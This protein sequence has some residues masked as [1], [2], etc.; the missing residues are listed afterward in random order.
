MATQTGSPLRE[1]INRALLELGEDGTS[2]QLRVTW[3]GA[4]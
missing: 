3:F 2:T 1:H 4:P